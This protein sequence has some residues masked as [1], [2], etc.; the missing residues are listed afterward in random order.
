M[1][2]YITLLGCYIRVLL[3]MPDYI[4][5]LGCYTSGPFGDDY[6]ALLGTA[7]KRAVLL[8][9]L[10]AVNNCLTSTHSERQHFLMAIEGN[11]HEYTP[12][13]S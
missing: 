8:N 10:D 2:D 7:D 11:S 4:T 3:G 12:H 9:L 6:M 5:L 1:P 13:I